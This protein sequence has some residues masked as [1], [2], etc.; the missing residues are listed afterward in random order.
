MPHC[1]SR[2]KYWSWA[3]KGGCGLAEIKEFPGRGVWSLG[4]VGHVRNSPRAPRGQEM[5][6]YQAQGLGRV[7]WED[8][9]GRAKKC[10]LHPTDHD[11]T[12]EDLGADGKFGTCWV[13]VGRM[14]VAWERKSQGRGPR[15]LIQ[16]S[17]GRAGKFYIKDHPKHPNTS[18]PCAI[19]WPRALR[20]ILSAWNSSKLT[21]IRWVIHSFHYYLLSRYSVPSMC[22]VPLSWNWLSS[23]SQRTFSVKGWRVHILRLAGQRVSVQ[24]LD[25][26]IIK[27]NR[28]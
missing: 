14:E 27:Q 7:E 18:S 24:I 8:L 16:T 5:A 13:G 4:W 3:S 26:A 2:K 19:S 21:K 22:P 28:S 25:A 20:A 9:R 11:Q 23:V 12:I 17:R 6:E 10:W 15:R 1:V